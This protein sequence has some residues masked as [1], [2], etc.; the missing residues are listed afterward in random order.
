MRIQVA[1]INYRRTPVE[2]REA[3]AFS[4]GQLPDAVGA[5]STTDG[6]EEAVILS[7]CNRVEVYLGGSSLPIV[8]TVADFLAQ[9]HGVERGVFAEHLYAEEDERAVSHLLQVASGLDSMVV[10]E[11]QILGQVREAYET[12]AKAGAAGASLHRLFQRAMFVA[13]RVRSLTDIG[14]GRSSIG[15][16]AVD[17]AE[18]IFEELASRTVLVIGAGEMGEAVLRSLHGAGVQ[19]TLVANRTL[20]RAE[21]LA[22]QYSGTALP[23]DELS[24]GL[25]RADIVICSTDAPH[26]IVKRGDADAAMRVRRGQPVFLIDIAVPRDI[27]PAVGDV[28]GCFLYNVDDLQAVVQE[29]MTQREKELGRCLAIVDEQ[30]Q[31]FMCWLEGRAVDPTIVELSDRLHEIKRRE[32]DMLLNRLPGLPKPARG[33]IERMADRLVNKILHDPFTALR[34]ASNGQ[35]SDGLLSAAQR[36]FGLRRDD[37]TSAQENR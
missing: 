37:A 20:S 18:H 27:E 1:G 31:N 8:D 2:V 11:A 15:S 14:T 24:K 13:K 5:L 26:Y 33:E 6:V 23:F 10:G 17:L 3:L 35:R 9:F 29:T 4:R 19:T 30:T 32:L 36:L 25:S 22:T 34:E 16:V 28:D 21:A 7:T 12:A